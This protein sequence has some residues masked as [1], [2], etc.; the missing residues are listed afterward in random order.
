MVVTP[1]IVIDLVADSVASNHT[2]PDAG[3]LIIF[4]PFHLCTP[5][6][7][8]GGNGFV[9]PVTLVGARYLDPFY[10]NNILVT[11]DIQ[12]LLYV[13]RF[14]TDN[15]CSMEFDLFGVFVK[16]VCTRNVITD[17]IS[18]SALYKLYA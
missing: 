7:I 6:P 5:S 3:N 16:D 14:T 12:N 8:V 4:R 13:R 9:L 1:L 15:W 17:C 10:F 18:S 2:T 11:P